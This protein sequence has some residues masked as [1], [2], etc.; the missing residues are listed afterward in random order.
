VKKAIEFNNSDLLEEANDK[1]KRYAGDEYKRFQ[2]TSRLRYYSSTRQPDL[3][4]RYAKEYVRMGSENKFELT[5]DILHTQ[6]DQPVLIQ[7]ATIWATELVEDQA[8]E[9]NSFVAA[10]LM[11][12]NGQFDKAKTYA[13]QALKFASESRS[14]ALPHIQKLISAIEMKIGLNKS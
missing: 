8:N 6:K 9:Q 10:Q 11:Y 13:D 2:Y 14:G 3:F 12:L 1:V 4:L 7:Q 5:N